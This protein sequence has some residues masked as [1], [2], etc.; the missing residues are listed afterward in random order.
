MPQEAEAGLCPDE[1]MGKLLKQLEH[2]DQGG[3]QSLDRLAVQY[4]L[5][6]RLHFLKGSIL[7]GLQRYDEGRSA[8]ARAIEIAPDFTLAR[9]QL[10]FL[11]LT[12]GRAVD[13]IG[14][15]T[16][17]FSLD[18]KEPLRVFAEGLTNLAGDNF[19]EARRLLKLGMAMNTANPL[20]N[21]DMQLILD[22]ISDA[23]N[24]KTSDPKVAAE[25]ASASGSEK[26]DEPAPASAVHQLLQ[27][28][29]LKDSIN[30]TK[31]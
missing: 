22:D 28:S 6:P 21:A 4:P 30:P 1:P 26:S 5:D 31:H 12:S 29:L 19:D 8:M 27:Q 24:P 2:D 15:W 3:L 18:E 17:L 11:D 16:P 10:G 13:A 23:P 9:F 14:V 7:A 20:I 25:T